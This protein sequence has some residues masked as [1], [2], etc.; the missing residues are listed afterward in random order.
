MM[1]GFFCVS[2]LVFI[3]IDKVLLRHWRFTTSLRLNNQDRFNTE[4]S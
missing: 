3:Y 1:E 4:A 2:Q